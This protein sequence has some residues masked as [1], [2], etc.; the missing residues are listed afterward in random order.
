MSGQDSYSFLFSP[1]GQ[2]V[3]EDAHP[4]INLRGL[5]R[6]LFCWMLVIDCQLGV[7]E[8]GL[9]EFVQSLLSICTLSKY[10]YHV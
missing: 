3:D 5:N 9:L 8:T 6:W 2:D 4:R 1:C 7:L 10:T